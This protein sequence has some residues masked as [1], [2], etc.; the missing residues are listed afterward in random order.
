MAPPHPSQGLR[1]D[2]PVFLTEVKEM[3]TTPRVV[4]GLSMDGYPSN[5]PSALFG[6]ELT[7]VR[8]DT[9][10]LLCSP[11][12]DTLRDC[13]QFQIVAQCCQCAEHKGQIRVPVTRSEQVIPHAFTHSFFPRVRTLCGHGVQVIIEGREIQSDGGEEDKDNPTKNKKTKTNHNPKAES[14]PSCRVSSVQE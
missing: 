13:N 5:C 7:F 3:A 14:P 9:G 4:K 10:Q 6:C 12:W 8:Q 2:C 11:V 1:L